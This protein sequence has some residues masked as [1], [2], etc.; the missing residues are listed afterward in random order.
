MLERKQY[1][2]VCRK[3][4]QNERDEY[5]RIVDLYDDALD[6]NPDD[7]YA[8]MMRNQYYGR[9]R[10]LTLALIILATELDRMDEQEVTP[11]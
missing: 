3:A 5:K 6:K 9:C 8:R 11:L 7:D 2:E 4:M 1:Y 10:G